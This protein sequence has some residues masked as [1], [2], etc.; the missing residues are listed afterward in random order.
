MTREGHEKFR[1][2]SVLGLAAYGTLVLFLFSYGFH[3]MPN[4]PVLTWERE[5]WPAAIPSIAL[6]L[7]SLGLAV[8]APKVPHLGPRLFTRWLQDPVHRA[9]VARPAGPPSPGDPGVREIGA[10]GAANGG[11]QSLLSVPARAPPPAPRALRFKARVGAALRGPGGRPLWGVLVLV[12]GLALVLWVLTRPDVEVDYQ[13]WGEAVTV[14]T[15][16]GNAY[17]ASRRVAGIGPGSATG[18]ARVA[19][20]GAFLQRLLGAVVLLAMVLAYA[21]M[22]VVWLF[23]GGIFPADPGVVAFLAG[24][25]GWSVVGLHASAILLAGSFMLRPPAPSDA[26]APWHDAVPREDPVPGEDPAPGTAAAPSR[27]G[28]SLTARVAGGARRLVIFGASLLLLVAGA[29]AVWM[30]AGDLTMMLSFFSVSLALGL[31]VPFAVGTRRLLH[32][33]NRGHKQAYWA[34]VKVAAATTLV[35]LLPVVH[36]PLGTNPALD[37]QF[38]EVFGPDWARRL[39]ASTTVPGANVTPGQPLRPTRY[40][41]VQN[42]FGYALPRADPGS[43]SDVPSPAPGS[44][45]QA[46]IAG[47]ARF[48]VTYTV[49]HP[50]Y[51]FPPGNASVVTHAFAFDAYLPPGVAFGPPPP[52]A[53][54][55]PPLPVVIFLHGEVEDRGPWNANMTSRYLAD[56]GYLVCDLSYGYVTHNQHGPDHAGYTLRQVVGQ[57]GQFTRFLAAHRAEY[58]AD[59]DAVY[60]CGRHLGGGLALAC[61]HGYNTTLA[62]TFAPTLRVRGVVPY[63]PFGATWGTPDAMLYG[64]YTGGGEKATYPILAGA[65]WQDLDPT[66]I[67]RHA[68]A[69]SLAPVFVVAGTHDLL[70]PARYVGAYVATLRARGHPVVTGWYWHGSDGFDGAHFSPYGQ[71]VVYYLE[72][73][74]ALTR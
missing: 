2:W 39:P 22:V 20:A 47:A 62:G 50:R 42:L 11:E 56:R 8:L 40:S 61:G 36:V 44:P 33:P 72:R 21:G 60:F 74:L 16:A 1:V 51:P 9:R 30:L 4:W 14:A 3:V 57:L 68:P 38:A 10:T 18:H 5:F 27:E 25:H 23:A 53:P 19:G 17:L 41:L 73:F 52:G 43:S 24:V 46:S 55:V 64:I 32:K 7:T 59:L 12:N 6:L 34:F 71:G 13:A 66:W 31:V 28:G 45:G 67:A 49:D 37:R 69:G 65:D 70:V 26:A 48:N 63:Y 29:A 15:I 58:H 35:F 54:P